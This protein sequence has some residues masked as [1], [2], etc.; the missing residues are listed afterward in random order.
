MFLY[1]YF[2]YI[3]YRSELG[4]DIISKIARDFEKLKKCNSSAN[5]FL[6]FRRIF[7]NSIGLK[8]LG[9]F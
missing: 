3:I 4:I 8:V 5:K 2:A 6:N 1:P 9:Y 7:K